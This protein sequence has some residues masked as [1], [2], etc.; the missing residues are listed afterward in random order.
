MAKE[1]IVVALGGNALGSTPTEQKA[2]VKQT[3][4]SI[5]TLSERYDVVVAHGN[6][7]Q[8]G[9]IQLTFDE[10]AK[11]EHISETM[12]LPECGAMSQGYI[13]YH[14]TQ[15]VMNECL[16]RAVEKQVVTL[17]TQVEVDREDPAFLKPTKP[18]GGF[19]TEEEAAILGKEN[20]ETFV[21]DSGRGY[22]KVVASPT[23]KKIVEKEIVERLLQQGTIVIACGG[24]GIP[25]IQTAHG[26]EGIAA[27]I[28]KDKTSSC[29]ATDIEADMLVILTAVEQVALHFG[30]P[31]M[32]WVSEMS[33]AKAKQYMKEGHFAAGSM[34]PKIE[35]CVAYVEATGNVALITSLAAA[36]RALRNE[37]GTRIMPNK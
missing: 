29:L 15:A 16:T 33:V 8:V 35:A 13:G 22:R 24:G 10:A 6:G 34:L 1:R 28:D 7:P 2:L 31:D 25:V 18:V 30:Q 27:V 14:L 17:L 4:Q 26:Y 19:Y 9:M 12:P 36:D 20:N 5:V 21:E 3:A 37:T 11:A 32:T 23:P